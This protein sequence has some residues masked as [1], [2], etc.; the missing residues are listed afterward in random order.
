MRNTKANSF[1]DLNSEDAF[2]AY[3][4][5]GSREHFLIR[6]NITTEPK[7]GGF[8]IQEFDKHSKAPY[9]IEPDEFLQ[10]AEFKFTGLLPFNGQVTSKEEYLES[11]Q[12]TIAEIKEGSFRKVVMSRTK[13]VLQS[14]QDLHNLFIRL[15]NKYPQAFVFL[16]HLPGSGCWAGASPEILWDENEK[17]AITMALAGTQADAGIPLEMVKW[18]AKEVDEQQIIEYFIE[19]VLQKQEVGYHKVGPY[20]SKA[21]SVVHIRSDFK[22]DNVEDSFRIAQLLHPGPAISG[23]PVHLAIQWIKEKEGHDR[24]H[25]CGFVGPWNL[26]KRRSLYINLRSMEVFSNACLLYLG[27]GITAES[28]AESEWNET[29]LKA[30]TMLSV[31]QQYSNS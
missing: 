21:G 10:N 29:E 20:T 5:P 4:L 30:S 7:T 3:S 8:V 28:E 11:V 12:D 17:E 14:D 13:K 26:N 31:I 9:Y 6:G 19:E 22:M 18:G 2:A 27:G 23:L 15:K 24:K 16:Y 1:V 25:Y